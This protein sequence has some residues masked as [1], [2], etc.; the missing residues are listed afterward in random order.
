MLLVDQIISSLS[1]DKPSVGNALFKAQVLAHRLDEIELKQ[2]VNWELKGYPDRS[3]L[4]GY[5]VLNVSVM[6][7]VSNMAQ[8]YSN[9]PLPL[10]HLDDRVQEHLKMVHRTES[11]Q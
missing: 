10:A 9:H 4:P 7:N 11:M 5:R 1:S 2:W 6:G 8:R 3:N